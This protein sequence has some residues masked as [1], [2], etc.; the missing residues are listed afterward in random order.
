MDGAWSPGCKALLG[1]GAYARDWLEALPIAGGWGAMILRFVTS[2]TGPGRVKTHTS[3]KCRKYN[4]PT[5]GRTIH[6]ER[7]DS[8]DAESSEMLLR[9]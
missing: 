7:F 2:A 8:R 1:T 6:A 4:S 5:R 9:E 3:E